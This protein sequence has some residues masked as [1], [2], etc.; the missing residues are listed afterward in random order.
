M[1][2]SESNEPIT[3]NFVPE[4]ADKVLKLR[5]ILAIRPRALKK[6]EPLA[7]KNE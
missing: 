7:L 3:I 6:E 5:Q 4:D 1:H 2:K